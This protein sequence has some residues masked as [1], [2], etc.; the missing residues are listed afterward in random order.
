MATHPGLLREPRHPRLQAV[1]EARV[2]RWCWLAL[3][4]ALGL[5]LYVG[6]LAWAAKEL[7]AGIEQSIQPLP[8][9]LRDNPA[10]D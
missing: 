3:A 9:A 4:G 5:A 7:E 10:T 1:H 6:S 2:R 8:M